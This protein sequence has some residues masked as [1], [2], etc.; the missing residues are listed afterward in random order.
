MLLEKQK[1][2]TK[3]GN[4]QY[5]LSMSHSTV[6]K[7]TT[8][9]PAQRTFSCPVTRERILNIPV[10][11]NKGTVTRASKRNCTS[12][13]RQYPKLLNEGSLNGRLFGN[14]VR[15][16]LYAAQYASTRNAHAVAGGLDHQPQSDMHSRAQVQRTT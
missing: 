12:N 14:S 8:V 3:E 15:R 5:L 9:D 7:V 16:I 6:L 2:Y 10:P 4:N 11:Q 13:I 1:A